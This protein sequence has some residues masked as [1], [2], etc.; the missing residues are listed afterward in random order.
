MIFRFVFRAIRKICRMI[1]NGFYRIISLM[2]LFGNC[3]VFGKNIQ[4]AGV[5]RI[6]VAMTA[7]MIIGDN[8]RM[9]NGG[10]F[11]M[12]GRQQ[13]CYFIVNVGASLIIGDNV[14]ISATAIVC[15]DSITIGNNVKIGGNCAIYDTDFHS[16]DKVFR[17][18][19]AT[20]GA[21]TRAKPVQI[22]NDVFVG[23]HTT[24]LKGVKIGNGAVVGSCSVV[25]KDI[26]DNE[27]WAGNPAKYIRT[28][29]D[30]V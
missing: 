3:V 30:S 5:P 11:N 22:G 24:I 1:S 17:R 13:P 18:D 14:G 12:I 10:R 25:T 6:D 20:D 4:S 19:S 2:K 29:S 7:T 15:S 21:N 16:I 8:F 27:L 9:N 28:L 23:A 26:P